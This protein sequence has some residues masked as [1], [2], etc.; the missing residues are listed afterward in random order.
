MIW[1][2]TSPAPAAGRRINYLT[3]TPSPLED[4][5]HVFMKTAFLTVY[6]TCPS[7][8]KQGPRIAPGLLSSRLASCRRNR[9]ESSAA[10]CQLGSW[11]H[12]RH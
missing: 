4:S 12:C 1:V 10:E 7:G 2:V 3:R 9:S 6:N 11:G 5:E 8:R